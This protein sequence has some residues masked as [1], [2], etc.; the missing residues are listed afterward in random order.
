MTGQYLLGVDIGTSGSKGVVVDFD[1]R[2]VAYQSIEHGV[3]SPKPGWYEQDADEVW[4]GDLTRITNALIADAQVDP[5]AIAAVGLSSLCPN[6][7]PVDE[8]G[9]PLRK[10]IL[11]CDTRAVN[12]LA[13]CIETLGEA[14]V[15]NVCGSSLSVQSAGPKVLWFRRHEPQLFERTRTIH[16][17][18]SYLVYKLTGKSAMDHGVAVIFHPL[19]N[20]R[21]LDWDEEICRC[22]DI[23]PDI[24]PHLYWAT[25]VVGEVTPQASAETGLGEGIPVITGTCDTWAELMSV[26]AVAEG[27]AALLYGTT[28]CLFTMS[29]TLRTHPRAVAVPGPLPQTYLLGAYMNASAALTKWFRDNFGQVEKETQ[30]ELGINAYQLLSDQAAEVPPGSEG[31]VILPYFAGEG[32]PILDTQARG[33]IIGLTLSHT[34]KHVYRALLEG[35]AY[36][37]RHNWETLQEA[38]AGISHILAVGGGTKSKV[39]TQIVSD[40]I[41]QDQEMVDSP[42]GA[43]YGDAFLAGYGV[44][45]F[46]DLT[47]LRERW[48]RRRGKVTHRPEEKRVYDKYYFVY[49]DLYPVT[50]D[51]MHALAR[52]S[53]IA[54]TD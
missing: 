18:Q 24:F 53:Q 10:A 47:P 7:L 33:L 38:G 8:G 9:Q 43:P 2:V 1:G 4:W 3:D 21:Q 23:R 37:L 16:D 29:N 51:S 22:L 44:G 30:H 31:L 28:M 50:R 41:G 48:A 52:L 26:G 17:A 34:R 49:R 40:V 35:V 13:E 39:W 20:I 32:Y 5:R 36:G 19:F 14:R 12:E 27:E 6:V 11:Y 25:Q 45:L 15:F 54:Q 46:K 42:Y